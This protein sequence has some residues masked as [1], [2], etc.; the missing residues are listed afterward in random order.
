MIIIFLDVD[1]VL[2]NQ[3]TSIGVLN[4]PFEPTCFQNLKN[5][6]EQMDAKIVVSS[7]IRHCLN[8][9]QALLFKLKEYDL[10]HRVIG[11]TPFINGD[12]SKEIRAYLNS[13][14]YQEAFV[15][16][17]DEELS[18][19]YLIRTDKQIGL[20]ED[21]V[22]LAILVLKRQNKNLQHKL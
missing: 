10:D 7:S 8:N 19:P 18:V 6:V 2:N 11:Y 15:V 9:R 3:N 5:L 14:D 21:D 4:Y 17:D 12:K 22:E 1:G 16:L 13:M 20:T